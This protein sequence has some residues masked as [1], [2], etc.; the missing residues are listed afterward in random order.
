MNK[1]KFY[2][3]LV[4]S[5]VIK[6]S[7]I[8][9]EVDE[10]Y[11]LDEMYQYM[12]INIEEL[13]KSKTEHFN[14]LSKHIQEKYNLSPVNSFDANKYDPVHL[15]GTIKFKSDSSVSK[16]NIIFQMEQDYRYLDLSDVGH[17]N[18]FS[19]Q[20]IGIEG[21]CRTSSRIQ[22]LKIFDDVS[23]PRK[24]TFNW[25]K[26]NKRVNIAVANGPFLDSKLK[27]SDEFTEFL[28]K[29]TGRYIDVVILLG[30]FIPDYYP[31]ILVTSKLF[32]K[33]FDEFCDKV[34]EIIMNSSTK[35]VMIPSLSDAHHHN[36]LPQPRFKKERNNVVFVP[37]PS[38]FLIN[39]IS[40]G[41][42]TYDTL[43]EIQGLT[44]SSNNFNSSSNNIIDAIKSIIEQRNF[45]PQYPTNANI[46]QKKYNSNLALKYTPDVL[47][48]N[49]NL[50]EFVENVNNV[51]CI[52]AGKF[53]KDGK[54]GYY[55][56]MIHETVT[57]EDNIAKR[58]SSN[59]VRIN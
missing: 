46:H 43:K 4:T 21:I 55:E 11:L 9:I 52:N 36:I 18:F 33:L 58:V 53:Q 25:S 50:N 26:R 44:I 7:N 1:K 6:E 42:C 47:L 15:I 23:A 31:E 38:I 56:V 57:E 14:T 3:K 51:V 13:A 37:N 54:S 8:E 30:P 24:N 20:V 28:K 39:D 22:V 29:V 19:G 2:S 48:F 32:S 35:I 59:F 45:I 12:H 10:T 5:D 17:Y 41:V 40:F 34:T 49:S 16:D 27:P